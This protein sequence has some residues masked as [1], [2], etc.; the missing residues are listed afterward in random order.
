VEAAAAE[1]E[2]VPSTLLTRV[3]CHSRARR[4]AAAPLLAAVRRLV[5]VAVVGWLQAWALLAVVEQRLQVWV[6]TA[7]Q[8]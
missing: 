4:R 8:V 2:S 7:L 1:E 6:Q 5:L 3:P